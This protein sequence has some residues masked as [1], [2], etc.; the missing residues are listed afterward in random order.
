MDSNN[1]YGSP[2]PTREGQYGGAYGNNYGLPQAAPPPTPAQQFAMIAAPLLRQMRSGANW[3]YWIAALSL[4]NS[5]VALLG[6]NFSLA[7]GLGITL[8]FD[9]IGEDAGGTLRYVMLVGDVVAIAIFALFGYLA[10]QRQTWAFI[11][12]MGLYALDGLL[13][14]YFRSWIGVAIHAFALFAM[15]G[16]VTASRK[17]NALE[18]QMQPAIG[19]PPGPPNPYP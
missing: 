3:F 7:L 1:S 8:L 12:G 9:A 11:V 2:Q 6:T 14:L 13:L 19:V 18:A 10:N 16:G 15:F 4:L 5:V 17:L